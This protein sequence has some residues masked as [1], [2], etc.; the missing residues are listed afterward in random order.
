MVAERRADREE[1]V[2][3]AAIVLAARARQGRHPGRD[4]RAREALLLDLRQDG[5][6]GPR[7]QRDLRPDRDARDRRARRR[8]GDARLLRRARADPLA[9]EADAGPVQGLRR[10]AEVQRL[11]RAAH[12]G[13]RARRAGRSRS[14]C[15]RARCT[16][17]PSSA[18]PRTGSYK[19]G[20][21]EHARDEEWL[22]WVKQ[23][24]DVGADEADPREFMK[25]FRTDL[26]DEEVHVFTPKGA[27]ED[28]ARR[29]DADRLRLRRA[30]RRRPPHGRREG[31]RPH[32]AAALPAA[33]RRLRR[34][35]HLEAGPR[36]V[37][38]LAVAR[39]RARARATR[40]ASGSR[41]RRA[42]TTRRRAASR[43]STR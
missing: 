43:S 14:R 40:S 16:R 33:E 20:R 28:A 42:R 18:S 32:R 17:R 38:R 25:S 1:H 8:R 12:D 15:A 34:D 10:D 7:V 21:R 6:E 11:P 27:G 22:A 5:Q 41:A 19:G 24:M 26:F 39:R 29:R 36:P 13:D 4:L 35:P 2:R 23:L 30:H 9:L 3:E 31:E 37:A